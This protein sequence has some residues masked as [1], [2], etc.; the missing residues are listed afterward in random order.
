MLKRIPGGSLSSPDLS[1][2]FHSSISQQSLLS[3]VPKGMTFNVPGKTSK[4][5]IFIYRKTKLNSR[6][7]EITIQKIKL[8]HYL[9][10][11][12]Q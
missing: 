7:P 6:A 5:H 1:A 10:F 8:Q 3:T 11:I 2:K 9:L 4:T 12:S